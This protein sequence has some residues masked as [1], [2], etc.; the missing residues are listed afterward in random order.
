[1]RHD[2]DNQLG[3]NAVDDIVENDLGGLGTCAGSTD[4]LEKD[5]FA[6]V[7]LMHLSGCRHFAALTL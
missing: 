1:M 2:S 6:R 5:E 7:C 4:L 3:D